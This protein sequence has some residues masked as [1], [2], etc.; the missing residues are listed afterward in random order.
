MHTDLGHQVLDDT[1]Q[2]VKSSHAALSDPAVNGEPVGVPPVYPHTTLSAAV[3]SA[4]QGKDFGRD[5]DEFQYFPE[6]CVAD[7]VEGDVKMEVFTELPGFFNNKSEDGWSQKQG[8]LAETSP[9]RLTA[10]ITE[11]GGSTKYGSKRC[12]VVLLI[13]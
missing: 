4:E 9:Q 1:I 12:F 11:K 13:V 8:K 2:G 10:V 3:E 7:R 5:A 6:G